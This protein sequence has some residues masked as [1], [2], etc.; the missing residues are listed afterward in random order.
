MGV[1]FSILLTRYPLVKDA[2]ARRLSRV[3]SHKTSIIYNQPKK[4]NKY[5]TLCT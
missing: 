2:L 3:L 5:L 4:K 1:C